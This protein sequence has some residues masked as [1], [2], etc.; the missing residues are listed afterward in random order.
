MKTIRIWYEKKDPA[1]YISLLDLQRVMQRA[2]KQ[3][4]L[5]VWYTEGF[6]PHI[7][8]TFAV[9]LALG[10][11]SV[12]ESLEVKTNEENYNWND[13]LMQLN[14]FLPAGIVATHAQNAIVSAL[15]IAYSQYTVTYNDEH[16]DNAVLAFSEFEKLT[17]AVVDKKGKKGKVKQIDLKQHI[18]IM[19]KTDGENEF[20]VT[21]LVPTSSTLTVNPALLLNFL[22]SE[23]GLLAAS[24]QIMR[25]CLLKQ[26]KSVFK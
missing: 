8:I 24:G 18:E 9:P 17:T 12:T 14:K 3:S 15:Q 19:N 6:N 2:L 22:Q 7:Y 4:K 21:L 16:K 5:P 25:T 10:Q 20:C 26:D 1:S 23:F 13:S 11:Q